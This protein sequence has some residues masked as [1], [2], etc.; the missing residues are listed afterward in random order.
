MEVCDFC[1][2]LGYLDGE[3]RTIFFLL[4][5]GQG[6]FFDILMGFGNRG[7]FQGVANSYILRVLGL[8]VVK[9]MISFH[10][11][12]LGGFLISVFFLG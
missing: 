2:S 10:V 8:F 9:E 6:L 5:L 7:A 11:S 4:L 1:Y 3:K 12:L